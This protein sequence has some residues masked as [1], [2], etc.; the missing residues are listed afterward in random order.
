VL[1][2]AARS[3]RRRLG[4]SRSHAATDARPFFFNPLGFAKLFGSDLFSHFTHTGWSPATSSR[5]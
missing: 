1:A 5:R 2:T 4:S 3:I